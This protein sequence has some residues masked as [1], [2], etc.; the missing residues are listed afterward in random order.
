MRPP[1]WPKLSK[2]SQRGGSKGDP[3]APGVAALR[4]SGAQQPRPRTR[5]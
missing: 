3:R 2:A 1:G 4:G 5:P